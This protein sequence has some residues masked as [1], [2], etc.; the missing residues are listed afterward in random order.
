[1]EL[2]S[3]IGFGIA[4]NMTGHLEQAGEASDFVQVE[5]AEARAPKGMFPFYVPHHQGQLV[6]F[7]LCSERL[8]LP[9]EEARV[10]IEPEVALRLALDWE[11]DAVV[12]VR[13]VAFAAY[14]DASIRRPAAKISEKKNWG[15]STK[16]LSAAWIALDTLAPGGLLDRF[17]LASFLLRDGVLHAYGEDSPVA[18]YSYFHEELLLWIADRL[19]HQQDHGPLEDLAAH[20]STARRP[21]EAIVAIG[22]TR[23]TSFGTENFLQPGDTALVVLYDGTRFDPAA[24]RARI[25]AGQD[26]GD[27]LSVL[28]Q[29][30]TGAAALQ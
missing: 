30:V 14:N 9:L 12:A 4:G 17:R 11:G 23:Y 15:P 2:Q 26:L 25:L 27:G 20:L 24:V 21:S 18:G 13:P 6:A 22:A 28:R 29:R 10:Q 5:T 7:P 8:R 16:G 3:A 19:N 1:M